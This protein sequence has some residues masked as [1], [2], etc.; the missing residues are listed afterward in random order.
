MPAPLSLFQN[1]TADSVNEVRKEWNETMLA[2][3]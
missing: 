2:F 3:L 1:L